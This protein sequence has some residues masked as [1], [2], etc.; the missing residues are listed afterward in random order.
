MRRLFIFS[1]A[2]LALAGAAAA[3]NYS[4]L[5]EGIRNDFPW[6]L[7]LGYQYT[8]FDFSTLKGNMSGINTTFDRFLT[9]KWAVE[10][11]TNVFFGRWAPAIYGRFAF[12]GAGARRVLH[13]HGKWEPYVHGD[14]GGVYMHETAYS[15]PYIWNGFGFVG[16]GGA[17]FAF[18][19]HYS[20][21]LQGDYLGAHVAGTY[22][23]SISLGAG[24]ALNF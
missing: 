18:H 1:V 20:L 3:Q 12:Y 15:G 19:P 5:Q 22:K 14:F 9:E 13:R 24:I 4:G 21:R 23:S 2:V 6:Q 11:D 16:G 10:A 7:S 8:H 17:D